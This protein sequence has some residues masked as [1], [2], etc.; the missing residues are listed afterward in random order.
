ME[1]ATVFAARFC[2]SGL[3][4]RKRARSIYRV[5]CCNAVQLRIFEML[6]ERQK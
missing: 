6:A 3:L 2:E 4:R 1:F 5:Y